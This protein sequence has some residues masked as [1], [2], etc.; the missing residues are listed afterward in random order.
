MVS[1]TGA[2]RSQVSVTI[3]LGLW[4][5][6]VGAVHQGGEQVGAW[7]GMLA[8]FYQTTCHFQNQR[9][10]WGIR[11]REDQTA[12]PP[13]GLGFINMNCNFDLF[14]INFL[15]SLILVKNKIRQL[16]IFWSPVFLRNAEVKTLVMAKACLIAADLCLYMIKFLYDLFVYN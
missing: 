10:G 4:S 15:K 6:G 2:F 8:L 5:A 3:E 1:G 9:G 16:H 11:P 7:K 14:L 13:P 12:Q